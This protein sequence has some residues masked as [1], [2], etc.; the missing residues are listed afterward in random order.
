MSHF[1]A[2][3]WRRRGSYDEL[4][5]CCC[6]Q[7]LCH[8]RYGLCLR[9]CLVVGRFLHGDDVEF[10]GIWID[11]TVKEVLLCWNQWGSE[12]LLEVE[13]TCL[14]DVARVNILKICLLTIV[15]VYCIV[16]AMIIHS[17]KNNDVPRYPSR[18]ASLKEREK[19]RCVAMI[20]PLI[21]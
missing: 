16:S 8:P 4:R 1:W 20:P 17:K 11:M 18:L 14:E 7:S 9:I 5:Q 21:Y 19:L 13:W 15:A 6:W 12:E 2:C 10:R 3:P